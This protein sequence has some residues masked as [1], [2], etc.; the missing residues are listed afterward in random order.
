MDGNIHLYLYKVYR[1]EALAI[2][3]CI[4]FSGSMMELKIADRLQLNK[5]EN[6]EKWLNQK[7][8][9]KNMIIRPISGEHK[10]SDG[11]NQATN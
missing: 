10:K 7:T 3:Y 11:L 4:M 1:F 5:K 8:K 2:R 6:Y 9:W